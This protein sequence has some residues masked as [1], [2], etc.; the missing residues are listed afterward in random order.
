MY[1]GN[2]SVINLF[3]TNFAENYESSTNLNISLNLIRHADDLARFICGWL[4]R[5]CP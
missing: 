1:Y 5:H 3:F 4:P 2:F